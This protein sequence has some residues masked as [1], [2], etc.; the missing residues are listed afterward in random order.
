MS[1]I[2]KKPPTRLTQSAEEQI[3][4]ENGNRNR[5]RCLHV[6]CES[7]GQTFLVDTGAEVFILLPS[8]EDAQK[9]HWSTSELSAANG[10]PIKAYRSRHQTIQL[11][12]GRFTWKFKIA[13]AKNILGADF[14]V[15]FNLAVD[16]HGRRLVNLNTPA[17]S[18]GF[19]EMVSDNILG[20]CHVNA[21]TSTSGQNTFE[22]GIISMVQKRPKLTEQ[23]FNL[24]K[25]K[26][27]VDHELHTTCAPIRCKLR[28]AN[29]EKNAIAK[30]K[31]DL[32]TELGITVRSNSPW[33]SSLFIAPKPTPGE[34]RPCGDFC[35]LNMNT[36]P[37][38]YQT[39][40]YKILPMGSPV[41][42]IFRRSTYSKFFTKFQSGKKTNLRRRFSHH[43]AC[44]TSN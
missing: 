18:I 24:S 14:L 11:G 37:D 8:S 44:T 43:L 10:S 29:P 22:A 35:Q 38:C 5:N 28:R 17:T 26:H 13:E 9:G 7:S 39:R 27:G 15:E 41:A 30:A 12:C 20:I 6:R 3:S 32:M 40:I 34:W 25:P 42:N 36:R 2:N 21:N 1:N 31:F 23:T 19:V 4:N 16:L 33:S